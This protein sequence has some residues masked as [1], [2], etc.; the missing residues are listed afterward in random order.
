[1]AASMP[2]PHHMHSANQAASSAGLPTALQ[3]LMDK[4]KL[5]RCCQTPVHYGDDMQA[6]FLGKKPCTQRFASL[7]LLLSLLPS[8]SACDARLE[9]PASRFLH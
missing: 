1:M 3:Y 5:L 7:L 4:H 6:S 9:A 2:S 8:C